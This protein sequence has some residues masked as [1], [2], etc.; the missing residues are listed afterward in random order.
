MPIS[1][2]FYDLLTFSCFFVL[3][4]WH[5]VVL[6]DCST[7]TELNK[8]RYTG[9][10]HC[11][12]SARKL[13]LVSSHLNLHLSLPR[14]FIGFKKLQFICLPLFCTIYFLFMLAWFEAYCFEMQYNFYETTQKISNFYVTICTSLKFYTRWLYF[15]RTNLVRDVRFRWLRLCLSSYRSNNDYNCVGRSK[16]KM[17]NGCGS[18]L[19]TMVNPY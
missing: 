2:F 10:L 11:Y 7:K 4:D 18:Y 3:Q 16:Y 15:W 13:A 8:V 14:A 17:S 6:E 19:I 9:N 5:L 12:W 1:I